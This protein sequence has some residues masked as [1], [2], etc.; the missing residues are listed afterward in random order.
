MSSNTP[1]WQNT[2]FPKPK[3]LPLTSINYILHT[4]KIPNSSSR[5]NNL[6]LEFRHHLESILFNITPK[7][8]HYYC[9]L[10]KQHEETVAHLNS[11]C[12]NLTK[13]EYI[14]RHDKFYSHFYFS[15]CKAL[16]IVITDKWYSQISNPVCK[17]GYVTMLWNQAVHTDRKFTAK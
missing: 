3:Y 5:N 17:D 15:I 11:G 1:T 7:A 6:H 10:C 9:W 16:G 13:N 8:L 12:P 4:D 14:M 2:H